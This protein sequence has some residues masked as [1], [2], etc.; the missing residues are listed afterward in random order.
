MKTFTLPEFNVPV[1]VE[2]MEEP[3]EPDWKGFGLAMMRGWG[4]HCDI[5][6]CDRFELAVKF[7]I[8]VEIPGGFNPEVHDDLW[9]DAERGDPWY[10]LNTGDAP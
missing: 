4:E 8:L 9:G 10:R 6:A 5:D 2:T 1:G 3:K 7:N